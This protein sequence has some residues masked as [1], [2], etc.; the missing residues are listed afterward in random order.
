MPG[1]SVGERLRKLGGDDAG[2]SDVEYVLIT[3]LIVLPLFAI[4]TLI[5]RANY[6]YFER[7]VTWTNLP[8]P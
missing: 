5:M 3:A 6:W 8:F 4:P 2:T 1:P 7:V